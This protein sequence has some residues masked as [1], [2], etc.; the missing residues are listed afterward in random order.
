MKYLSKF[1]TIW[2]LQIW[3]TIYTARLPKVQMEFVKNILKVEIFLV[4]IQNVIYCEGCRMKS[5]LGN[6]T[7]KA[8]VDAFNASFMQIMHRYKKK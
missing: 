6:S 2:T 4:D 8:K 1:T 7:N 5:Y 3:Y